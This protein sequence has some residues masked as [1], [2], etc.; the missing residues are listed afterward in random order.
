MSKTDQTARPN[1]I[2]VG[3]LREFVAE[4]AARPAAGAAT[5][6]VVTT[7]QGGTRTEAR[8][9]PIRLGDQVLERNFFI[10]ADEPPELLGANTAANPQELLLAGL[11]A[12][13]GAT[14]VGNAAAMNIEL[15]SLTIRARGTLDLRG[16]L[17]ID[18]SVN[19]G[20]DEVELEV[21]IDSP[22]PPAELDKLHEQ[23]RR[24]SPNYHNF[25]RAVPLKV[26]T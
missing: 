16:F 15:R 26:K 3:A 4:V 13:V 23:V 22:A 18:A 1:G 2:D 8:P 21:Q 17:G 14:Y 12:C 6:G 11:N 9:M 25:V 24:V 5:F 19:P 7:W 20:Y 10:A